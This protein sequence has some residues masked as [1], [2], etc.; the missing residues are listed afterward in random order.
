MAGERILAARR[1]LAIGRPADARGS[2]DR[3]IHP[4]D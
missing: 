4:A 2:L 3:P 1:R